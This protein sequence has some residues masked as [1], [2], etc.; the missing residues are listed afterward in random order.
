MLIL[1]FHIWTFF[2]LYALIALII[3][4]KN[5]GKNAYKLYIMELYS[6]LMVKIVIMPIVIFK[7]G[8][9][10]E[11]SKHLTL[12]NYNIQPYPLHTISV[13]VHSMYGWLQIGGN[14][15]LLIPLAFFLIYFTSKKIKTAHLF[16]IGFFSSILI[17]GIQL[18]INYITKYP[19][20]AIDIDDIILNTAGYILGCIIFCK[21]K[22]LH[23]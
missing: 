21:A 2:I 23:E 17:E 13:C 16:L 12:P 4:L 5:K 20:H 9:Y 18:L 11:F 3:F 15:I 22:K 19:C 7:P 14:I 10:E 6:L 1:D 8:A